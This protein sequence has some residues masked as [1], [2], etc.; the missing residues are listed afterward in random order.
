MTVGVIARRLSG[1]RYGVGRYLEYLLRYWD[2]MALPS[3]EFHLFAREPFDRAGLGVSERFRVRVPSP[4]LT[5][6]TWENVVLPGAAKDVDVLFGPSYTIPLAYSGRTVVATHSLNEAQ[7]GAHGWTYR[8]TY[9]PWYRWS[10]RKANRVVVPSES[11]RRDVHQHYGVPLERIDI[12]PEGVDDSFTPVE[13]AAL[14]RRTREKYFGSDRPYILFV[15][16]QSQRRNIPNLLAAFAEVKRRHSLPHGVLLMG[17]NIMDRPI[18]ELSHQLG[19]RDSVVQ[20]DEKFDDHRGIVP[21]YSAA[22]LY[23]YP[24]SY[25]GFSLTLVEAMACGTPAVTV[26]RAALSEIANGCAI[27]VD[28]P[29]VPLLTGALERGLLDPALRAQ[30]RE[31]GLERAKSLRWENTARLTLDVLR[32]VAVEA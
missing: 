23:A 11:T 6:A 25:D 8:V 20:L 31:K 22:D 30:L 26:N 32:R 17:P 14:L 13:D 24:S 7:P 21:V 12:A 9:T 2:K 27:L 10:A 28:A 29:T 19:I 4:R 18:D 5:G 15:G 3:D 16:K 1:R